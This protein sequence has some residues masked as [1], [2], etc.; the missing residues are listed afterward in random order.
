M[1]DNLLRDVSNYASDLKGLKAAVACANEDDLDEVITMLA[2]SGYDAPAI[3]EILTDLLGSHRATKAWWDR[4]DTVGNASWWKTI[5][6]QIE[7]VDEPSAPGWRSRLIKWDGVKDSTTS[8][9]LDRDE[10][11][12]DSCSDYTL[13]DHERDVT[14]PNLRFAYE[15]CE[16][17]GNVF[18]KLMRAGPAGIISVLQEAIQSAL[19]SKDGLIDYCQQMYPGNYSDVIPEIID[20]FEG[21][22]P[23]RHLWHIDSDGFYWLTIARGTMPQRSQIRLKK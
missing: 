14:D 21:D 11:K 16:E 7:E 17:Q 12:S 3:L 6:D 23:R 10:T 18:R 9:A 5:R 15:V 22:D 19:F 8:A 2:T 1:P 13:G 20:V 4:T